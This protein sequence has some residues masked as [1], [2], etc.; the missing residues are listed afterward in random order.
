VQSVFLI[1]GK[2]L[3]AVDL[4]VQSGD[5]CLEG[6]A[7]RAAGIDYR[8]LPVCLLSSDNQVHPE[9]L[10]ARLQAGDRFNAI[11]ALA[12]LPRLLQREVAPRGWSVEVTGF[13]LATRT[14]LG[15]LLQTSKGVTMEE[16]EK[17]LEQPPFW[18]GEDV[19]R[20]QAEDLAVLLEREKVAYQIR[21]IE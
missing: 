11:I 8:F 10:R 7:M 6:Q 16:A 4:T 12:D 2:L 3:A 21:R 15:Q 9:P 1:E 18:V 5:P 14:W 20:G 17:W 13:S 19:T